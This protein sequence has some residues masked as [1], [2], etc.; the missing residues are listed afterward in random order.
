MKNC[1]LIITSLIAGTI[2]FGSCDSPE[3]KVENAKNELET[4]E[5]N[6]AK[7]QEEYLAD[8]E[9]YKQDMVQRIENNNQEIEKLKLKI[10]IEDENR[11]LND[12]YR[13]KI[14]I[15]EERNSELRKK[16]D[17]YQAENK[18]KWENFK[19]EFNRDINELGE[20]LK[21]FDL[22]RDK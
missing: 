20:S 16:I 19:R 1:S 22:E 5:E 6:L 18:D 11:E 8:I 10:S 17:T 7:A 2:F 21:N 13:K 9:Y 4:A 15:L 3:G 12:A 14:G